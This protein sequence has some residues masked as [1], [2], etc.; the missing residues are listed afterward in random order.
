MFNCF[1]L[2][3]GTLLSKALDATNSKIHEVVYQILVYDLLFLNHLTCQPQDNLRMI[4]KASLNYLCKL[5][6]HVLLFENHIIL[7]VLSIN[8]NPSYRVKKI[9]EYF[10]EICCLI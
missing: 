4:Q 5:W 3:F 7:I 9:S 6:Y 1:P 2:N 8:Q 10:L